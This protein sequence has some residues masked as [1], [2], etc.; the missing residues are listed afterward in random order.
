LTPP[1][2]KEMKI[3]PLW[4]YVIILIIKICDPDPADDKVLLPSKELPKE[5]LKKL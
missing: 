1:S 4:R 2:K 5:I 3:V